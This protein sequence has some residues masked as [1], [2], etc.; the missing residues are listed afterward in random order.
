MWVPPQPDERG[1]HDVAGMDLE[2]FF[3]RMKRTGGAEGFL[4]SMRR[5]PILVSKNQI[6]RNKTRLNPN[7]Y[8]AP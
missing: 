5:N 2:R 1:R 7:Q 4:K 3:G 8:Q 6:H